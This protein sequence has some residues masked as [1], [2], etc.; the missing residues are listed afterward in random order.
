M[1]ET[2]G[3]WDLKSITFAYFDSGMLTAN[4]DMVR[5]RHKIVHV[6]KR[7]FRLSFTSSY[8]PSRVEHPCEIQ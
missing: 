1:I 5:R 4:K 3:K 6:D 2:S 7:N 8:G